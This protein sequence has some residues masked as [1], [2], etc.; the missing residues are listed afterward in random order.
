MLNL[1]IHTHTHM[2]ASYCI[3]LLDPCPWQK[4]KDDEKI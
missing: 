3:P 4:T 2:K 1:Y